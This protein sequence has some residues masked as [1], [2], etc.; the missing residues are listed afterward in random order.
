MWRLIDILKRM[1]GVVARRCGAF[2]AG[3]GF[4]GKAWGR[5]RGQRSSHGNVMLRFVI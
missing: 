4:E 1:S 3:W 2:L 5:S